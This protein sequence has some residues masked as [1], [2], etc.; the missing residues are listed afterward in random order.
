MQYKTPYSQVLKHLSIDT[1][2]VIYAAYDSILEV[3]L[4]NEYDLKCKL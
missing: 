1:I 2:I 3:K 4:T